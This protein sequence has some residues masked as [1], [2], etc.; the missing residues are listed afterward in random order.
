MS[1]TLFFYNQ[2]SN[3]RVNYQNPSGF[4]PQRQNFLWNWL[5]RQHTAKVQ[6]AEPFEKQLQLKESPGNELE[7]DTEVSSSSNESN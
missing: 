5:K 2:V 4:E 3:G 6:N 1:L 7:T